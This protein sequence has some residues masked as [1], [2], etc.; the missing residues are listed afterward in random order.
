M[1]NIHILPTAK[2]Q[3]IYIT[4]D[5][6]IGYSYYLDGDLVRKGVIDDKEYWGFRK[7]Y[8]KI[9]MT[10]DPELIKDGVQE[11]PDEFLQWFVKNQSCEF[12]E[13][14]KG[15]RGVDLFNYKIII[16]KEEPN[17]SELEN[18]G[19]DKPL[20]LNEK[21]KQ[22]TLEEG[23][24]RIGKSIDYSEFDFPSFKLGAEWQ[25]ERMYSEEDMIKASEYGYNFHKTTQFPE[26]EFK[27]SCIRNTQ[28]WLVQF[29]KK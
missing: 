26:Q 13:V 1:K 2:P 12:V 4:S 29:N 25:A 19:L 27:D 15:Y 28:Q 7:E 21:S 3:N 14:D 8:K 5:D 16:P 10:T 20:T 17:W 6:Y 18:S 24:D 9:I 11:I 22:E 23:F